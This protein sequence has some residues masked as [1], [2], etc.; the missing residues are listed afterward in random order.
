MRS[1]TAECGF[2]H[3]LKTHLCFIHNAQM[4]WKLNYCKLEIRQLKDAGDS[5]NLKKQNTLFKQRYLKRLKK[6]MIITK[7]I[8][9]RFKMQK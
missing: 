6:G 2:E 8:C 4:P 3:W 1:V 7:I 9:L 5:Y